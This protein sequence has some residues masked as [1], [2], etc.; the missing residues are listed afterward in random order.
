MIMSAYDRGSTC[1]CQHMSN[2]MPAA[3]RAHFILPFLEY[4]PE[5][6]HL[7]PEHPPHGCGCG[8]GYPK[9]NPHPHPQ[10]SHT[11]HPHGLPTPMLF[12]NLNLFVCHTGL[13]GGKGTQNDWRW[14]LR[15]W[16][17]GCSW[18]EWQRIGQKWDHGDGGRW[19]IRC[20]LGDEGSAW[21]GLAARKWRALAW[22]ALLA[23]KY[24]SAP[25]RHV[26]DTQYL[27]SGLAKK[28][29]WCPSSHTNTVLNFEGDSA[30]RPRA[31]TFSLARIFSQALLCPVTM[32]GWLSTYRQLNMS[33]QSD[34]MGRT[35]LSRVVQEVRNLGAL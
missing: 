5:Y 20:T 12:P 6:T 2:F 35:T 30:L 1:Q 22:Y 27:P 24:S 29:C 9:L 17:D 25:T 15:H 23:V 10:G 18:N 4:T 34:S 26:D 19:T 32:L 13:G 16:A 21:D 3:S 8:S 11:Q 31:A 14:S 7:T 28:D 33:K